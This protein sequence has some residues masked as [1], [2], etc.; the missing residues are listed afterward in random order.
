MA[1]SSPLPWQQKSLH[2]LVPVPVVVPNRVRHRL[3]RRPGQD[4]GQYQVGVVVHIMRGKGHR[5]AFFDL[6]TP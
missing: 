6:D 5:N 3:A 4:Q 1:P 2:G